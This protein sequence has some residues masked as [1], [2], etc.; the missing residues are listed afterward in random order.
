[1]KVLLVH[2]FYQQAGGEDQVF[3]FEADVLARHGFDVSTF[4]VD[5]EGLERHSGLALARQTVWNAGA[6]RQ[7]AALVRERQAEVVHFHNTFPVLSPAVY[8]A[9]RRAGAAVV[10]TLHN[11]RLGCANALLFREGR[12]CQDCLGH[13]PWPAVAH[14]CYRGSRGASAVVATLQVGHRWRG[15]YHREVDA[16]IA[17]TE[18]ARGKMTQAGLPPERLHVVP[19]ALSPDPGMGEGRGGYAL[20]VGR[21]TPEKGIGVLLRAWEQLGGELPLRI[22]GEGPLGADVEQASRRL[23]GV[24]WLG[25]RARA[26]VLA[27]MQEARCLIFPSEWFEGFPM[28]IVEA[29]AVG[30]PVIASRMGSMEELI[31][32][33][34]TGEHFAAG[35]PD[36]LVRQVRAFLG[37][38]SQQ[39]RQQAR[40]AYLQ[41]YTGEAH[42]QGLTRVYTQA[43]VHRDAARAPH[44]GTACGESK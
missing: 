13:L 22:V 6:G 44:V 30:L 14:A 3:R 41:R 36:D 31:V 26:D 4:T 28:T 11:Y 38:S 34:Q 2:N 27:M 37:R 32:P 24:T 1:M 8:G 25:Q 33:G 16:F 42:V 9:A 35:D 17:L 20:F 29:F 19:N 40:Q 43:L 10:Q 15:T 21:L 5:N 39:T 18:F 12:V 23:P 7:V